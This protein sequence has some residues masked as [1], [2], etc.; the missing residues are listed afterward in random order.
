MPRRNAKPFGGKAKA[1]F[2]RSRQIKIAGRNFYLESES[3]YLVDAEK[4]GNGF[5]RKARRAYVS[6]CAEQRGK[7]PLRNA[8]AR[9]Q[10]DLISRPFRVFWSKK[11]ALLQK[12]HSNINMFNVFSGPTNLCPSDSLAL[13]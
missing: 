11:H 6:G 10:C 4:A 8:R 9:S 5:F 3:V 12:L 7:A 2:R 1:H 13:L